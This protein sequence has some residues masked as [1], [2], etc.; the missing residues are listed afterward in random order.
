[1]PAKFSLEKIKGPAIGLS[2]ALGGA[3]LATLI[4]LPAPALLGATVATTG[5][6][7]L[8]LNPSI[9]VFLRNI[10]FAIIGGTLGSGITPNI[11]NDLAKYP[12]SIASLTLCLAITM[13]VT[14][15]FL[16][17]YL[18]Q[19][20]KTAILATSPGALSIAIALAID[21]KQDVRSIV[22]LQSIRLLLITMFMPPVLALWGATGT[23]SAGA[24]AAVTYA[25]LGLMASAILLASS[26]VVGVIFE[27]FKMPAAWLL[28]GLFVSGISHGSGVIVGRY[29]EPITFLG[30]T[31]AGAVIGS[32]FSGITR[33]ELKT[34]SVAGAIT[35][36]FAVALSAVMA[37]FTALYVDLPFAQMW[38]AFAPGGVE[39][40]SAMALALDLD[41]VFVAI[42]H[43]YR[44][45]ALILILPILM[46][47]T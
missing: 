19:P 47:W 14:S 34:L 11:Y 4:G 39:G 40:M 5:A 26:A 8:Q 45:L 41:P 24:H 31:L 21:L 6:A 3:L 30:F 27:R 28:A 12:I 35:T 32:R 20:S 10:G 2:A 44:I 9:P 18:H 42:H 13:V 17:R 43:I 23:N 36:T 33:A 16:V 38:I 15:W 46:R 7:L 29:M 37:Y 1:M 25:T 22:V